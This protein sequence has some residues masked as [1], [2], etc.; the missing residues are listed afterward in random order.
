MGNPTLTSYSML[1]GPTKSY[2]NQGPWNTT[3]TD[4]HTDALEVPGTLRSEGPNIYMYVCG[5]LASC[6]KGAPVTVSTGITDLGASGFIAP[7]CV[8]ALAALTA[9]P[10]L[11]FAVAPATLGTQLYGWV[12]KRGFMTA[13]FASDALATPGASYVFNATTAG[14]LSPGGLT[15]NAVALQNATTAVASAGGAGSLVYFNSPL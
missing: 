10:N 8:T 11:I 7:F 5:G 6:T 14:L 4:Q 1:G 9:N 13:N 12:L 3:L 2:I 15:A